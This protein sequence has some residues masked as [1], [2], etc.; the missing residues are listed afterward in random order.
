MILN[1]YDCNKE[2]TRFEA[3]NLQSLAVA[4]AEASPNADAGYHGDP[5]KLTEY[6]KRLIK[7]IDDCGT[8]QKAYYLAC[9]AR[10]LLS[11]EIDTRKFFQLSRCIINLMEEDL[12]FLSKRIK[13]GNISR[14]E[15]YVDDYRALGLIYET[16][17]GFSYSMRA[18][19]LKKYV[20]C[21]ENHPEIPD[22]FPP[23][24]EPSVM[25]E[26]STDKMNAIMEGNKVKEN[27]QCKRPC[28]HHIFSTRLLNRG[29]VLFILAAVYTQ[30]IPNIQINNYAQ[31]NRGKLLCSTA[32]WGC[33]CIIDLYS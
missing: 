27:Q 18:F 19:E 10:A 16:D 17:E 25:K 24:Y 1:S 20:L 29:L 2:T 26:I 23:K 28:N 6:A 30:I 7:L 31:L 33:K 12:L 4:L 22:S 9:L 3:K 14:D 13:P 8:K 21:Y 15:D 32:F 5:E 11:K